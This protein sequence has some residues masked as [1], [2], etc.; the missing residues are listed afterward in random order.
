MFSFGFIFSLFIYFFFLKIRFAHKYSEAVKHNPLATVTELS[1]GVRVATEQT[2]SPSAT[3]G[4]W[5]DTGSSAEPKE[6]NGITHF[7]EHLLF[8]GTKNRAKKQLEQDVYSLGALLNS[9][10]QRDFCSFYMTLAPNDVSKAVEILSDLIQNSSLNADDIEATRK[11]ILR[12]LDETQTNY[13]QVVMDNLHSVAY[14][15]TPLGFSKYGPTA[16]IERFTKAD[17]ERG[18]DLI[19][20]APQLVV[21][22]SGKI[23]HDKL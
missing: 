14:Q 23:D 16:N 7:I 18:L 3:V 10:T 11:F 1:N 20:K 6:L 4:I 19:F 15:Q 13:E 12:E 17:I 8:Q 9:S 2:N 21:A 5:A 22:C